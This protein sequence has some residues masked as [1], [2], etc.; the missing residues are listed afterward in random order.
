MSKIERE[1]ER[2]KKY[3]IRLKACR[4]FGKKKNW[5]KHQLIEATEGMLNSLEIM[6]LGTPKD[7]PVDLMEIAKVF[8]KTL[9]NYLTKNE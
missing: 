8:G 2:F 3:N 4:V 1:I 6:K 7:D 9:K 5:Y